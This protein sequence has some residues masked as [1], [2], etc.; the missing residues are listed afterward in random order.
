[1][2]TR[3]VDPNKQKKISDRRFMERQN[4][5]LE[6][7]EYERTGTDPGTIIIF[8]QEV[9]DDENLRMRTG[10]RRDVNEIIT[11]FQRLGFNIYENNIHHDK[12]AEDI[13]KELEAVA[14]DKEAMKETNCLILFF[15][16][17]GDFRDELHAKDTV[18]TCKQVWAKFAKCEELKHK[19]K[20]FVFQA[21]KGDYYTTTSG[22][23]NEY[24][25]N[26]NPAAL[27]DLNS[28][29]AHPLEADML[30]VYATLEGNLS[31]RNPLTGTWF[32]QELCKNFS[33]YG[34]RDDV[35]S[36]ITRT[37]KCVCGNY[38]NLDEDKTPEI[39]KQMPVFVST[40]S[41]KF[42]L[43]RYKDRNLLLDIQKR[44]EE[45]HEMVTEI[46]KQIHH[47]DLEKKSKS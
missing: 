46:E 39:Q 4:F 16:T 1:M 8:N 7:L 32:I 40:L 34:R 10:S 30:L 3:K 31:F 17:H 18:L 5:S 9:F 45:I 38:Y 42:Y 12:T 2:N 37:I 14:N 35:I 22:D 33:S 6:K 43:N 21:C 13:F 15:L 11:C 27:V 26:T 47:M 19:P 23:A 20:M 24:N 29:S 41:K 36:M 44:T 25:D 28:F